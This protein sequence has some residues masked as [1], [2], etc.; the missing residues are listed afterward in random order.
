MAGE[1]RALADK[2][3]LYHLGYPDHWERCSMHSLAGWVNG[4]A[5]REIQIVADER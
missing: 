5:F 4:L 3:W 2:G 1:A